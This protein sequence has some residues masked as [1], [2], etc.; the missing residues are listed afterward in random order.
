MTTCHK[1]FLLLLVAFFALTGNQVSAYNQQGFTQYDE[2]DNTISFSCTQT[3]IIDLWKTKDMVNIISL[4]GEISWQGQMGFGFGIS[5][6]ISPGD[7]ISI[8]EPTQVDEKFY[9]KDSITAKW[10][11]DWAQVLL[12]VQGKVS[13]QALEVDTGKKSLGQSIRYFFQSLT[14]NEGL[15]PY[16]INLRYGLK[17]GSTPLPTFAYM[18]F[19]LGLIAIIFTPSL[20]NNIRK[21]IVIL[22]TIILLLVGIR[23][24]TEQTIMLWQGLSSWTAKPEG[25]KE[26]FDK[27]DFHSFVQTFQT[28]LDENN[29][30]TCTAHIS[31]VAYWPFES[32]F[33]S[34]YRHPCTI[35]EET[36][37]A[38]YVLIYKKKPEQ[39]LLQRPLLF[40]ENSNF[41]F[42]KME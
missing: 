12:L 23:S 1:I 15:T 19:I 31:A 36:R 4:A 9:P 20:R 10:I 3:C 37:D 41:I 24:L 34:T 32:H 35:V 6:Q 42:G 17:I 14:S 30:D 5:N 22:M 2:Q 13:T 40:N 16:S 38:D 11:P 27:G 21:N 8:T 25:Q 33:N 39:T 18:L 28:M 7:F 26:F 29:V